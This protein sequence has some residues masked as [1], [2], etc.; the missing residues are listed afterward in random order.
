MKELILAALLI[1]MLWSN[2]KVE[3]AKHYFRE[4]DQEKAFKIFLEALDEGKVNKPHRMTAEEE[5]LYKEAILL[6]LGRPPEEA[7]F[8]AR[9]IKNSLQYLKRIRSLQA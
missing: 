4:Q 5:A 2:E 8:E 3:L 6:Y 7:E 1:P 9:L